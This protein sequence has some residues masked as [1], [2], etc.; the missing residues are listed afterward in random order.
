MR[1]PTS[2]E[3]TAAIRIDTMK[4]GSAVAYGVSFVMLNA[5]VVME[6]RNVPAGDHET[7]VPT[8]NRPGKAVDQVERDR[9]DRVDHHENEDPHQVVVDD[10]GVAQDHDE[11]VEDEKGYKGEEDRFPG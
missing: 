5:R 10:A 4:R 11:R 7:R 9:E 1:N 8:E 6:S 2:A 3:T